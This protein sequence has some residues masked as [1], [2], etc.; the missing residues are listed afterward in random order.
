MQGM[1]F[2]IKSA[3][4]AKNTVMLI[5]VCCHGLQPIQTHVH[6]EMTSYDMMQLHCLQHNMVSN[7]SYIR[8]HKTKLSAV[9]TAK[10]V[11]GQPRKR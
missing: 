7:V 2:E 8:W 9:F 1:L 5:P 3:T 10:S 11:A 4:K 6:N